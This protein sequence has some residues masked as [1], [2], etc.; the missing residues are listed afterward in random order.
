M[1]HSPVEDNFL[2]QQLFHYEYEAREELASISSQTEQSNLKP[3]LMILKG[4]DKKGEL[5]RAIGK[6]R[7]SVLVQAILKKSRK[8]RCYWLMALVASTVC[9]L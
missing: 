5:S 9:H 7:P 8:H 6:E 3:N 2:K 1:C 4:L